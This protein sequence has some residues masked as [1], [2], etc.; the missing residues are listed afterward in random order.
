MSVLKQKLKTF[1]ALFSLIVFTSCSPETTSTQI[2][3][4]SS[5]AIYGTDDRVDANLNDSSIVEFEGKEGDLLVWARATAGRIPK[6]AVTEDGNQYDFHDSKINLCGGEKFS[7]QKTLPD[8]TG[9]LVAEDLLVTA[10]HCMKTQKDCQKYLWAFD[11]KITSHQYREKRF[12]KENVYKCKE[13]IKNY[14]GGE[15]DSALIRLDRKVTNRTPYKFRKKGEITRNTPVL[16][17]GHPSGLPLKIAPDGKSQ[18]IS[19]YSFYTDLDSFGGNSG[20]PVINRETGLIEGI[21]VAGKKDYGEGSYCKRVEI[22][23]KSSAGEKVTKIEVLREYIER[24]THYSNVEN[25]SSNEL[26]VD[27]TSGD[28]VE[29]PTP[30]KDPIVSSNNIKVSIKVRSKD[31]YRYVY[32]DMKETSRDLL[33]RVSKVTYFTNHSDLTSYD[34]R[35]FFRSRRTFL[36]NQPLI[37]DRVEVVMLSGKIITVNGL[38]IH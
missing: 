6:Y 2:K 18:D 9:F 15:K 32:F 33:R 17:I 27:S 5:G 3:V 25:T 8:C 30:S 31:G 38:D 19:S 10:G 14:N 13:I 23:N 28:L 35:K 20:S 1:L 12:E 36:N 37:L 4:I 11:Y 29:E 21:L 34:R 22:Y 24:E 16:M 26:V 7:M